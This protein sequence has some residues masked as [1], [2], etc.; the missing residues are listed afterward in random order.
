MTAFQI[1]LAVPAVIFGTA[2]LILVES[3]VG[4]WLFRIYESRAREAQKRNREM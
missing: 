2:V 4:A 1:A 3:M